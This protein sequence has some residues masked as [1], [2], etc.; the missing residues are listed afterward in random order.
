VGALL[1][2]KMPFLA[3]QLA[4]D[5]RKDLAGSERGKLVERVLPVH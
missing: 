4:A 3:P 2:T 5:R 1:R